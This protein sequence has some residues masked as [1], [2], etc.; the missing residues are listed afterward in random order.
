MRC[1]DVIREL[2]VPTDDRDSARLAEHLANCSSCAGWS[3]RAAQLDRLWVATRPAEPSSEVW[4]AMWSH[5][6]NSLDPATAQ[7]FEAVSRPMPS[8]RRSMARAE[9]PAVIIPPSS[10][11]RRWTWG[12]VG[13]V[14]LAQAAAILLAVTATWHQSNRAPGPADGLADIPRSSAPAPT[15]PRKAS[16]PLSAPTVEIE[17]GR[18]VVIRVEDS[19]AR[20]VDL[21]PQTASYR[22][23]KTLRNLESPH[24]DDWLLMLNEVESMSKPIVAMK[25]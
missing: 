17:E 15:T 21:T 1:D 6:A 8:A 25:E 11:S 23:E 9:A 19:T 20:I 3:R 16:D 7:G 24:V 22:L 5:L 4:G 13:L 12:A 10:R 14:G 18:V 2:A